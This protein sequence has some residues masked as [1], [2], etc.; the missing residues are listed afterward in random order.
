MN[1]KLTAIAMVV[2]I[3]LTVACKKENDTSTYNP[4]GFWRGNAY[5]LIH[6]AMLLKPDGSANLYSRVRGYDT[7]SAVY[8]SYGYYT[9]SGNRVNAYGVFNDGAD[10]MYIQTTLQSNDQMAGDFYMTASGELVDCK[11]KRE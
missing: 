8:K 6:T 9:I 5:N 10:T 4:V 2:M 1:K 3:L 11:L 7:S